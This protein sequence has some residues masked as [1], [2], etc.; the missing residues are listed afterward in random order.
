MPWVTDE[1][2]R[3]LICMSSR[4]CM[5]RSLFKSVTRTIC[6]VN[7]YLP[8]IFHCFSQ[9]SL[10]LHTSPHGRAG[11]LALGTWPRVR[12]PSSPYSA[13]CLF[14]LLQF[15]SFLLTYIALLHP[16]LFMASSAFFLL[17]FFLLLVSPPPSLLLLISH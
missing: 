11:L 10:S 2:R 17:L 9:P 14:F 8:S 4:S 1:K 15:S 3:Q 12:R 13:S 7:I 16:S 5:P 6:R